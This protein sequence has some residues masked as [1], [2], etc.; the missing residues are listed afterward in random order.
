[1]ARIGTPLDTDDAFPS[2]SLPLVAGG[3]LDLRAAA[4]NGWSVLLVYRGHW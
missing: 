4:S 2:L 1:M 3:A